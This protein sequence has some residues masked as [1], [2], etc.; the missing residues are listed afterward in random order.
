MEAHGIV[1]DPAIHFGEPCVKG[2]RIPVHAVLELVEAGIS[3][4]KI[5][6]DH[7]PDLTIEDVKSCVRYA[8]DLVKAE[9]IHLAS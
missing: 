1:V 6:K 8:S 2:T 7:Y 9:E 3:F 5:V 4:D